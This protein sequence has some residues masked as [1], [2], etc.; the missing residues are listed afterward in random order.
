MLENLSKPSIAAIN[1]YALGGGLELAL[2][3]S[4]RIASENSMMGMP[5]VTL[6]LIPGYG[7]TQRL[8]NIVGKGQALEMILTGKMISA[9]KAKE[10][11]LVN[12]VIKQEELL[13]KAKQ[14]ALTIVKNSPSAISKAI[15]CV[16]VGVKN[17]EKGFQEEQKQFGKCF[18]TEDFKEGISAFLE[19][20]KPDFN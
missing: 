14:L 5:E 11:G 15:Q 4:F 1:G 9:K 7:G 12:Y 18:D 10:I 17:I 2:S 16:N 19:K 8:P 20:R 13:L 3:C 6:G